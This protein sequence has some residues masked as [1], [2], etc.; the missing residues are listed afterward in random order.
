MYTI[1]LFKIG[2]ILMKFK[3]LLAL[4]MVSTSLVAT[5]SG[6][7]GKKDA[8]PSSTTPSASVDPNKYAVTKP[9]TIEWWHALESQY[10]PTLDKVIQ[11]FQSKNP[12]ITVKAVFQGSYADLNEKLV[13]A[14]AAGTGLP[15]LT[16][17]NTPYVAQY[18]D[19][20]ICE[21]LNPYIQATKFD[22]KDFGSG[23]ITASSFDK[24][25]VSLPFQISTQVMYYNMDMA[26]AEGIQI[27]KKWSEM[28]AF[29]AKAAKVSGG[30]TSRY[31]TVVPGWDQWYF[32]PFFINNGIKIVDTKANKT[33]L[34]SDK[35]L[36]IAKSIQ[37]WQKD[38]S[39]YLAYGKD[40]SAN[41]RQTFLDGKAFSVIHTSSLYDMYVKNAKFKVGMAW[42][43]SGDTS[44]S[45]IGGNVLLIPEKNT[46]EV[47]N[48][49]WALLSYLESPEV[50]MIWAKETGY[51]P[52]RNSVINTQAGKD[53]LKEKPTFQ[54]IFDNLNNI[55]PRIQHPAYS[56]LAT[57]W[58][59]NLAKGV[60][61]GQDLKKLM[62]DGAKQINE[63][64]G[65]K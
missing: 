52:T 32:E 21:D 36:T 60:I 54:V 29:V 50:N 27:P 30:T 7:G 1:S 24:K 59:Q 39:A 51:M 15:A 25:Q 33:D 12:N 17:A 20:G 22:I 19:A 6:C 34:N 58:M 4:L 44:Y 42:L 65:D 9:I 49:A 53:F 38:G 28:D 16:V 55:Q 56:Q 63:V 43:P 62:D 5:L 8:S 23:L 48:A 46:Q 40:A 26:A 3:K 45:E 2:G 31:A 11:N 10:Q 37:K 57:I 64:L 14:S 18:G 61:E 41:M 47:K 13:A 35:A